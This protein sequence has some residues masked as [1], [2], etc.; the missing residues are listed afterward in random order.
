MI[1]YFQRI[2]IIDEEVLVGIAYGG[3]Q[4]VT[5]RMVNIWLLPYRNMAVS[6]FGCDGGKGEDRSDDGAVRC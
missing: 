2:G 3:R 5:I 4:I 1:Q 6:W